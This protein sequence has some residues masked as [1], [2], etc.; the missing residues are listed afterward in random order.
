MRHTCQARALTFGD[1]D[2][3]DSQ[4]NQLI[5]K[6]GGFQLRA[7]YGTEPSVWYIDYRLGGNDNKAPREAQT[8]SHMQ[9]LTT[10]DRDA[11]RRIYGK[12]PADA[13]VKS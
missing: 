8:G 4:V 10:V 5:R 6:H 7:E 9:H 11:Y 3:P 12:E 13:E 1:L 2:D